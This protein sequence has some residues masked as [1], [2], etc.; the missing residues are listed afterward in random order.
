MNYYYAFDRLMAKEGGY[1]NHPMDKGGPTNYGITLKSW[2]EYKGR[3]MKPEDIQAITFEDAQ[4]FYRDEYWDKL[5]LDF[6]DYD[7]LA[8]ALFDQA[9][10]RGLGIVAREIQEIVGVKKDGIIGAKSLTAINSKDG[11]KLL[12]HF[13]INAQEYYVRIVQRS[14]T[15]AVFLLGWIRR[16]QGLMEDLA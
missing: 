1:V 8:Y 3:K 15:Q 13:V 6:V 16:T 7:P 4:Q 5:R 11:K 12:F 14:P 2:E 10:N 9:V